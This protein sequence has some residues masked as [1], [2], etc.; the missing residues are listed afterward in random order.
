MGLLVWCDSTPEWAQ[1]RA[2]PS[3]SCVIP[4]GITAEYIRFTLLHITNSTIAY[5]NSS[6]L[7]DLGKIRAIAL[8]F[9]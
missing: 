6:N 8:F 9:R 1:A 2:P 3:A 4:V 5:I 7:R